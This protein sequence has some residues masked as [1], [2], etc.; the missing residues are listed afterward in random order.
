MIELITR[1]VVDTDFTKNV[2]GIVVEDTHPVAVGEDIPVYIPMIMCNINDAG[3]EPKISYVKTNGSSIFKNSI[4]CKPQISSILKE[5]NYILA[6]REDNINLTR[7]LNKEN[8]D[9]YI[10]PKGSKVDIS[11]IHGKLSSISFNTNYLFN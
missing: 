5:Q 11:F 8:D 9:T 3:K 7:L 6:Q 2:L 10:L 4:E 1:M